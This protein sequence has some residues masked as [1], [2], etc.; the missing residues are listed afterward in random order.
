MKILFNPENGAVIKDINLNGHI[1]FNPEEKEEFKPGDLLQFEDKVADQLKELCGFLQEL[2][3]KE[4][5]HILDKKKEVPLFKCDYPECNFSTNTKIALLG[6]KR[7]HVENLP[8]K[9]V[10]SEATISE[11]KE[12]DGRETYERGEEEDRRAGL[13]GPGLEIDQPKKIHIFS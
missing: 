5:K 13:Y 9:I 1:F 7:T 2:T 6:H 11:K 3:P 8:I 10:K 12:D 4:A